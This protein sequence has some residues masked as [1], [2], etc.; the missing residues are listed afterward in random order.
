MISDTR[1]IYEVARS[2]L[3][4]FGIPEKLPGREEEQELIY[5]TIKSKLKTRLGGTICIHY[6]ISLTQ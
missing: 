1:S 2:R 4:Q 6:H 5:E 3:N